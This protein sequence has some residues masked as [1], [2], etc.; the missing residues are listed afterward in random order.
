MLNE[1]LARPENYRYKTLFWTVLFIG[2]H[3]ILIGIF[4]FF[5]TERFYDLFFMADIQ[6]L[7][8]VRQAGLF[9]FCLGLFNLSI[10]R[11]IERNFTLINVTIVTKCLAVFFLAFQAHH[12]V[13][14][15]V[16]YLAAVLDGAMALALILL[17]R[18]NLYCRKRMA[19]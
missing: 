9:L 4:I 12:A 13:R 5:F 1:L 2:L 11:G 3:S 8:F 14:P 7:F 10:L 15:A 6:N 17:S 16:I 19:D 18:R